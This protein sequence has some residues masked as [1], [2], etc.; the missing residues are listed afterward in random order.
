MPPLL[1]NEGKK[2]F[3]ER[4][5]ERMRSNVGIENLNYYNIK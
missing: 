2:L 4:D 3:K 1:S 5:R